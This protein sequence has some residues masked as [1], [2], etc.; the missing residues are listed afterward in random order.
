MLHVI[1]KLVFTQSWWYNELLLLIH[2]GC[3]CKEVQAVFGCFYSVGLRQLNSC[4][5][6]L[7]FVTT[8]LYGASIARVIVKVGPK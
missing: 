2:P 7:V 5:T 8:Q 3:H 4:V 1:K 6:S